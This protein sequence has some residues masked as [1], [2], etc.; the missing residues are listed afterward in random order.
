MPYVACNTLHAIW[1]SLQPKPML[2][3]PKAAESETKVEADTVKDM[4]KGIAVIRNLAAGSR[5]MTNSALKILTHR[6]SP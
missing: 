2:R 3:M 5:C 6:K 1:G 4:A